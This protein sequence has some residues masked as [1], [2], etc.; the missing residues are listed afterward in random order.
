MLFGSLQRRFRSS[1][2]VRLAPQAS[3]ALDADL[4]ARG[5][6]RGVPAAVRVRIV[7]ADGGEPAAHLRQVDLADLNGV[8]FHSVA[9]FLRWIGDRSA[10]TPQ[11]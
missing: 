2:R 7:D 8:A 9:P 3:G 10:T 4:L 6:I 11:H 1:G 5:Q